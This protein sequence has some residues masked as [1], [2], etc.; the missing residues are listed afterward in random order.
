MV[1]T[2]IVSISFTEK[3]EVGGALGFLLLAG[4]TICLTTSLQTNLFD[5]IGS[6]FRAI[7]RIS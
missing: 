4:D 3:G 5:V 1:Y 7:A 2:D 6:I